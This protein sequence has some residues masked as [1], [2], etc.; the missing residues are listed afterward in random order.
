M[1]N[2]VSLADFEADIEKFARFE[3][4]RSEASEPI[5]FSGIF[6]SAHFLPSRFP[7]LLLKNDACEMHI[8]N[9][10]EVYKSLSP[11]ND[12]STYTIR[13]ITF[14]QAGERQTHTCLITCR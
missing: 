11:D 2:P 13:S 5:Y 10:E 12:S 1:Q 8:R 4:L 3:V 9:I 7:A 6:L 14:G